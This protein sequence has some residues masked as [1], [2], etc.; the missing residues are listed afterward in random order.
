MMDSNNGFTI[1]Y[2]YVPKAQVYNSFINM[3]ARRVFTICSQSAGFTTI[4]TIF[5]Q[6]LC[7]LFLFFLLTIYTHRGIG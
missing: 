6:M 2:K 5:T 4:F 7:S 1:F 3:F